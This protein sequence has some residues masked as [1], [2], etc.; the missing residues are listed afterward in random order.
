MAD[1]RR[2]G[3][4]LP[5]TIERFVCTAATPWS[6]DKGHFA[7]HPDAVC[8][9]DADEWERYECPHCKTRF[10]VEVPQ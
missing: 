9:Y 6:E 10:V 5:I 7:Q 2:D 4:N 8:V 3:Y 1:A